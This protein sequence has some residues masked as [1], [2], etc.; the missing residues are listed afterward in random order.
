M[1]KKSIAA[2]PEIYVPRE[3]ITKC[4]SISAIMSPETIGRITAATSPI[5]FN[6]STEAAFMF[7]IK[8]E[9]SVVPKIVLCIQA[10]NAD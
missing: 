6:L 4:L 1:R 3:S 7:K 2:N 10:P 9:R 5:R 8:F